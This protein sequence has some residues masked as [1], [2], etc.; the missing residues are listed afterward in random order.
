[1]SIAHFRIASLLVFGLL[2]NG[3]IAEGQTGVATLRFKITDMKGQTA[4]VNDVQIS[5]YPYAHDPD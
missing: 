2:V 5:N 3:L 1:M 4:V